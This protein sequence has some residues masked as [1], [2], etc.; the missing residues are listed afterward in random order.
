MAQH[1]RHHRLHDARLG[2]R[3]GTHDSSK[4]P[5]RAVGRSAAYVDGIFPKLLVPFVSVWIFDFFY[6]WFHRLQHIWA[7]LWAVH[8]LHHSDRAVNVTTSLRHH[9]LEEPLRAVLIIFPMALLVKISP[10]EAGVISA[11]MAQWGYFIHANTRISL[12]PLTLLI[13]G[14]QAHRVH[15]SLERHHL[16]KNFAAFLPLWDWLF[17]TYAKP[18]GWPCTGLADHDGRL[19]LREVLLIG[20]TK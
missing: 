15:H 5:R 6:Y 1:W 13:T 2:G 8:R 17:G 7:P 11:A 12:G 4:R 10:V 14:P 3:H 9:W 20:R 16:N 19:T 18:S